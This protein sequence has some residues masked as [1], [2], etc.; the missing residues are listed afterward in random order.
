MDRVMVVLENPAVLAGV[1]AVLGWALMRLNE[2]LRKRWPARAAIVDY[3]W[4]EL[5]PLWD[6]VALE[7]RKAR[8]EGGAPPKEEQLIEIVET[9]LNLFAKKYERYEGEVPDRRV[10]DAVA[11]ELAQ[12]VR[13]VESG[14]L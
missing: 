10:M 1:A 5:R 6:M 13:R 3:W 11:T 8:G 2:W 12:V 7:V 14:T 9:A 4:D